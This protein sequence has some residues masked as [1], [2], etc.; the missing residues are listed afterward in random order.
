MTALI[1]AP[2]PDELAHAGVQHVIHERTADVTC[3]DCDQTFRSLWDAGVH[4]GRDGHVVDV[5]EY[6]SSTYAPSERRSE[7]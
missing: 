3:R 6:V 2:L 1:G 4:A 5:D 7:A